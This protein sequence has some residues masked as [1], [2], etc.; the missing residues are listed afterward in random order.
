MRTLLV[1][2]CTLVLAGCAPTSE[3]EGG[4]DSSPVSFSSFDETTFTVTV[5][6]N[7]G[8]PLQGAAVTVESVHSASL[9]DDSEQGHRVFL[10]GLSDASGIVTG[11]VRLP[12]SVSEVDIV[13]QQAGLTGPWTDT[14]LQTELG[15]FA[16]SSRQTRDVAAIIDVSV[17]LED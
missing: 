16:P 14:A 6:D 11:V 10:R 4:G 1:P 5:V 7:V 2:V 8:D 3:D 9:D 13:V 12:K 17:V 15:F